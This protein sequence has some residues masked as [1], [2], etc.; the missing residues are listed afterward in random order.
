M[1]LPIIVLYMG[2]GHGDGDELEKTRK[3][4]QRRQA[5]VNRMEAEDE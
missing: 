1:A 2:D 4:M 5:T 3:N